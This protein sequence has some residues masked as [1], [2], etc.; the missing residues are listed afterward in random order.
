MMVILGCLLLFSAR[1]WAQSTEDPVR[2]SV[3]IRKSQNPEKTEQGDDQR[4]DGR[5]IRDDRTR[6]G[7]EHGSPAEGPSVADSSSASAMIPL[8]SDVDG[9]GGSG[10]YLLDSSE[11]EFLL[12]CPDALVCPLNVVDDYLAWM[13]VRETSIPYRGIALLRSEGRS[14]AEIIDELGIAVWEVYAALGVSLPADDDPMRE[15]LLE[16]AV[17]LSKAGIRLPVFRCEY[18]IEVNGVR[19]QPSFSSGSDLRSGDEGVDGVDEIIA[20]RIAEE[21]GWCPDQLLEARSLLGSWS[22][23]ARH[24]YL[25]PFLFEASFGID[26]TIDRVGGKRVLRYPPEKAIREVASRQAWPEQARL[27]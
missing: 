24:I 26:L 3:P 20:G 2:E 18:P 14:W 13:L 12:D 25:S 5:G 21:T 7:G 1:A 4:E 19:D 6:R 22:R 9:F 27:R 17:G 11:E 8:L 10:A 16:T 23:V 15:D